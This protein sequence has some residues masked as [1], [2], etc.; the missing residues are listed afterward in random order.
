MSPY[1]QV[2]D[3]G[4][5]ENIL[6]RKFHLADRD[7]DRAVIELDLSPGS[8]L[9]AG[10]SYFVS[11]DKYQ[12]SILGL[13]ESNEDGLSL[14][15]SYALNANLSL[16]AFATRETYDSDISGAASPTTVWMAN[17]NDR[18]TT[19]GIGLSGKLSDA[20]NIRLDY[21][22]AD[23]RGR[24]ATDSGAGEPAFPNLKTRLRDATIS[25]NYQATQQWGLSLQAEH[26]RY[27]GTDWQIDDLGN[28]GI[29]AILT[30]G[31][32]S[33]D[34]SITVLRVM[35]SYSF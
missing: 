3:P 34:Y 20:L 35:A 32:Q 31:P 7:R 27:S 14:D 8:R 15:L 19:L 6:M 21:I 18:F 24:I 29:S 28:D 13:M 23:S 9:S 30:L 4:L 5:Q 33:P 1:R 22:S 17:T 12:Q 2:S 26:E 25:L 10:I 16:H 11:E